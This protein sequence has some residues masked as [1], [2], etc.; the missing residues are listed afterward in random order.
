VS[1]KQLYETQLADTYPRDV[2]DVHAELHM[3]KQAR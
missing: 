2:N 3:Q 1:Y